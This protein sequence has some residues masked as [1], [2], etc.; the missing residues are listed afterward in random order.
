MSKTG[1][2]K[3]VNLV[4]ALK[5]HSPDTTITLQQRLLYESEVRRLLLDLFFS[6][7]PQQLFPVAAS[8]SLSVAEPNPL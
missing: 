1:I 4:A 5:T 6:R 2:N 7:G 3:C 8:A